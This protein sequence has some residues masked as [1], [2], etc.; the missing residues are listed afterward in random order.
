MVREV[1]KLATQPERTDVGTILIP[2][3]VGFKRFVGNGQRVF[4]GLPRCFLSNEGVFADLGSRF[5]A[6]VLHNDLISHLVPGF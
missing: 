3:P 2:C 5:E 4:T 6:N 1:S